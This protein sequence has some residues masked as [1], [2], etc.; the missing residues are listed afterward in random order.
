[1]GLV[2]EYYVM[3]LLGLRD[4]PGWISYREGLK[5][6]PAQHGYTVVSTLF[7]SIYI[8]NPVMI[9]ISWLIS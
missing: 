8:L 2:C 3:L 5:P 4:I 1:M 9:L 6:F 7:Y